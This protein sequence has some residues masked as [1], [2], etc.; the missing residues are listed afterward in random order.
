MSS[1]KI[2]ELNKKPESSGSSGP[3]DPNGTSENRVVKLND[4]FTTGVKSFEFKKLETVKTRYRIG[5][6]SLSNS[7]DLDQT[8]GQ[9]SSQK[10]SQKLSEDNLLNSASEYDRRKNSRFKLNPLLKQQLKIDDE[11]EKRVELRI[12]SCVEELRK[13]AE[14]L[15]HTQGFADGLKQGY[16]DAYTNLQSEGKERLEQLNNLVD[17]IKGVKDKLLRTNERF[18][19]EMIFKISRMII[20]KELETDRKF[21]TRLVRTLIERTGVGDNVTIKISK[22]DAETLDMLK[23]GAAA[24]LDGPNL[25]VE[26]SPKVIQGGCIIETEWNAI[27]ATLENQFNKIHAALLADPEGELP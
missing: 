6:N 25:H 11:E 2:S 18:I 14:N 1:F 23:D 24:L 16:H 19:M 20:L 9:S 17:S 21:L 15:G 27:D 22:K 12:Q 10:S 5:I 13:E 4:D 3:S 7:G 26:I 8:E